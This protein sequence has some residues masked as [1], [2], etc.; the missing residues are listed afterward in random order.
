MNC[1]HRVS[2]VQSVYKEYPKW[3]SLSI[4][5]ILNQTFNDFEYIIIDGAS[6]DST[7]GIATRLSKEYHHKKIKII[8]EPDNG[9]YD[10]MN[11]G[12]KM[13]SGDW[14]NMMNAGDTFSDDNVLGDIFN[15][16]IPSHINFIYSDIY[17]ATTCGRYFLVKMTCSEN[18]RTLV[19]QSVFYRRILHERFGYYIVSTPIIVSDYLFF[20][21]IPLDEIYKTN[22]VIAKYEGGGISENGSWC[23][24]G[25]LCADVVYR[26][27]SF[28]SI[29]FK[30]GLWKLKHLFPLKVR[31]YFRIK[32]SGV[33]K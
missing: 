13:A 20:L 33:N 16:Y 9:I 10:A 18:N 6:K 30:Y 5:S 17:K 14:I 31:E 8:S 19:H 25:A 12:V 7:V 21:Q 4:E 1:I 2:V 28:W 26:H 29:Y 24:Q 23:I 27:S 22:I 3:L 32:K 11:K 15:A